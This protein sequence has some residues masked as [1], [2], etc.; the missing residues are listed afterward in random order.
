M[1]IAFLRFYC[2]HLYLA[3]CVQKV[4]RCFDLLDEDNTYRLEN[5]LGEVELSVQWYHDPKADE[6]AK[7]NRNML[8]NILHTIGEITYMADI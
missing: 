6:L 8:T 7:K 2:R 3:V 5:K 1:L 4:T